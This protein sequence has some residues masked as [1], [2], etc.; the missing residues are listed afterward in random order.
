MLA[1]ITSLIASPTSRS[2]PVNIEEVGSNS[3][4]AE[5]S[6]RKADLLSLPADSGDSIILL[7]PTVGQKVTGY[8][9]KVRMFYTMI[10]TLYVQYANMCMD[11][12]SM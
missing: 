9:H 7:R 8:I 11:S 1:G 2:L 3:A 12:L 10:Y 5:C 6:L 4:V